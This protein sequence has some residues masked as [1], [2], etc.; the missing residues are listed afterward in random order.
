MFLRDLRI[1]I[2]ILVRNPTFAIAGLMVVALGIGARRGLHRGAHGA[3]AAAA[4]SRVDRLVTFHVD[5]PGLSHVP[6]LTGE[7]ATIVPVLRAV[8]VV[9][10]LSL[11]AD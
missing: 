7:E 8:R 9:P 4:L 11:R 3:A 10:M 6:L 2:R 5:G 1:G